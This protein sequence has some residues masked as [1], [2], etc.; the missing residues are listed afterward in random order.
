MAKPSWITLD[1]SS[2]TGGG[3]VEVT[4]ATNENVISRRGSL[5]VQTTSGITKTVSI[6][7]L[8]GSSPKATISISGSPTM[9]VDNASGTVTFSG[10]SCENTR[11]VSCYGSVSSS[12]QAPAQVSRIVIGSTTWAALPMSG[13]GALEYEEWTSMTDVSSATITYGGLGL[14]TIV[15]T[16]VTAT[17]CVSSQQVIGHLSPTTDDSLTLMVTLGSQE[18]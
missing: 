9:T 13:S 4:A 5:T 6:T 3:S 8:P 1:K 10:I 7:Q 12:M 15:A 17:I 14:G 11:M 2:G 16:G 18:V